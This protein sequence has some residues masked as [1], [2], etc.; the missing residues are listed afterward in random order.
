M[1]DHTD[2]AGT[3]V[4]GPVGDSDVAA[5]GSPSIEVDGTIDVVREDVDGC[6]AVDNPPEEFAGAVGIMP[7]EVDGTAIAT[8]SS[9][10]P[11]TFQMQNK[12]LIANGS[13]GS[14]TDFFGWV[15]YSSAAI[16][17]F[18]HDIDSAIDT[19]TATFVKRPSCAAAILGEMSALVVLKSSVACH[20]FVT[21]CW[22]EYGVEVYFLQRRRDG[23]HQQCQC[24]ERFTDTL[25]NLSIQRRDGIGE[26]LE[27]VTNVRVHVQC[28]KCYSRHGSYIPVCLSGGTNTPKPLLRS[29]LQ[30]F[31]FKLCCLYCRETVDK[32]AYKTHPDRYP[33]ICQMECVPKIARI[34][35]TCAKRCN[36]WRPKLEAFNRLYNLQDD[37]NCQCLLYDLM[38]VLIKPV[39]ARIL[40]DNWIA[41]RKKDV[42]EEKKRI[43]DAAI[44]ILQKEIR[45]D[46]HSSAFWFNETSK[47]STV[48]PEEGVECYARYH[49]YDASTFFCVCCAVSY[50]VICKY[51]TSLTVNTSSEFQV[52]G[53]VQFEFDNADHNTQ[54]V[55]GDGTFHVMGGVQSPLP[56]IVPGGCR[57]RN[58][59]P[60]DLDG[61]S[62]VSLRTSYGMEWFLGDCRR[63]KILTK[64][65]QIPLPF[66]NLHPSNPTSC[67]TCLHF[68]AEECRKQQQRCIVTFY[69]PLF[70]KAMDIVSQADKVDEL[71]KVIVRLGGCHLLMSYMEAVGKIMDGSGMEQMWGEV[72]SKNAVVHMANGHFYAR[73][74]RA[75]SVSQ[76]AITHLILECCEEEGFLIVLMS[77]HSEEF[78]TRCYICPP[79]KNL[80]KPNGRKGDWNLHFFSIQLTLAHL[81][82]AGHIHYA[83]SAH[84]YLQNMSKLK[85][86][87][88][89]QEFEG[90]ISQGYF[91]VWRSDK[92][93]CGFWTDMTIEQVNNAVRGIMGIYFANVTQVFTLATMGK[94]ITIDKDP[95]VVNPNQLFH[96]IVCVVRSAD[97]LEDCLQYELAPYPQ[98]LFDY[99]GICMGTKSKIMQVI[100]KI[101]HWPHPALYGEVCNANFDYINLSYRRNV[102]V[103]FTGYEPSTKDVVHMRRAVPSDLAVLVVEM[104]KTEAESGPSTVVVG[105]DSDLLVL[106]TALMQLQCAMYIPLVK[107]PP[108]YLMNLA[109]LPP[110]SASAHQ[111]SLRVYHQVQ[112]WKGNI[113]SAKDWGW[114]VEQGQYKPVTSTLPPAPDILLHLVHCGDS[115]CFNQNIRDSEDEDDIEGNC[116]I[117]DNVKAKRTSAST[118]E[119]YVM[120]TMQWYT[121]NDVHRLNWP[122]QSP[123]LNPREHLWDKLARRVRACQAWQKSIAQL[124]EWLQEEWRRIP[125]DVLHA[126]THREHARQ[127]GC[128]YNCKRV[129]SEDDTHQVD[130]VLVNG[131]HVDEDKNCSRHVTQQS[132]IQFFR[133]SLHNTTRDVHNAVVAENEAWSK[134][135]VLVVLLQVDGSQCVD[136]PGTILTMISA[137]DVL[138]YANAAL[139]M[140]QS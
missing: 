33:K 90:F 65:Q 50:S 78:T 72:F 68:A 125:V 39:A 139:T 60:L 10:V 57:N 84:L 83:K 21:V 71:S 5:V 30:P 44:T 36:K 115:C 101:L 102:I 29:D 116:D 77:K 133:Q 32:E 119:D 14:A 20:I 127:G 108:N 41:G 47:R 76:V 131:H 27:D 17:V 87:L 124:M 6:T 37:D 95:V 56:E 13:Y 63:K 99:V 103:G 126:H 104:A 3:E 137:A 1:V 140:C 85:T 86:T 22:I 135:H 7:E 132:A 66:I 110:T 93:W 38:E 40:T 112:T 94:T 109:S 97:N 25:R 70:I 123:D 92:F 46:T 52:N 79:V 118:R 45:L 81:H 23:R 121:N 91:T 120:A 74:L 54:T 62:Q 122:A 8:I 2:A 4:D 19:I 128:C 16:D 26:T 114:T 117:E 64:S 106:I 15:T 61:W 9:R 105:A 42:M 48:Q 28:R 82:A 11:K 89:D 88:S 136:I 113:F 67:N 73:A 80:F 100:N 35:S 53:F 43:I 34:R 96:R 24:D 134:A 130:D 98:S 69:Q 129:H 59:I 12:T 138:W 111:H 75:H 107:K 51:E 55:D 18:R 49:F 31:D 58:H